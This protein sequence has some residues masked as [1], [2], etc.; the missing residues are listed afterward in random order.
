MSNAVDLYNNIYGDYESDAEAAVRKATYGEDIGQSSWMTATEW[1]GFGDELRV[2]L[3]SRVLEVGSGSGGPAVYLAEM[4]RCRVTGVDINP[5]GIRNA[6][7][8]AAARHVAE[9]VSFQAIDASKPLPFEDGAFDA[10]VSNDAMCHIPNRLE[11]LRD[12]HR[13]LRSGGRMLFTDAM[14]VT[15]LIS[16]E[17]L[18]TRSSIGWYVFVPPG[19]NERLIAEAGLRLLS[20]RD[21]TSAAAAIAAR[22]RA[23]REQHRTALVDREGTGNFDGLQRFL[24][25]VQRVSEERRLSRY[26]YLA[27][28]TA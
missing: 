3:D 28:K 14:I 11:V 12:W 4:R 24:A 15:G 7:R 21:L 1:L 20:A 22:W 10:V 5:H 16:H 25:C 19:E 13:V 26:S 9:R 6:Q 27:E 23:A 17:E 8:L 2:Q 18:A